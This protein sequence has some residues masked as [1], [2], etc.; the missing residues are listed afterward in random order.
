MGEIEICFVVDITDSMDQYKKQTQD[1][2]IGSAESIRKETG[3]NARWSTI[4]YQDISEWK[5]NENQYLQHDF[6]EDAQKIVDF[7]KS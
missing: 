6:V 7:L 5:K 4:A 2:I 1:C 3:R